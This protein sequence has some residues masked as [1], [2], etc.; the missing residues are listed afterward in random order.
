MLF[1]VSLAVAMI[2]SIITF[3]AVVL[4]RKLSENAT[5]EQ[6]LGSF[7]LAPLM[8]GIAVIVLLIIIAAAIIVFR[9][10][11]KTHI[12]NQSGQDRLPKKLTKTIPPVEA[13]PAQ[14][15]MQAPPISSPPEPQVEPAPKPVAEQPRSV[16]S[17]IKTD[18][19]DSSNS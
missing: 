12:K 14:P 15:L 10:D 11:W 13:T 19:S 18:P 5:G 9:N 6:V 2:V 17:E 16:I 4:L 8:F 3:S 7:V 1:V